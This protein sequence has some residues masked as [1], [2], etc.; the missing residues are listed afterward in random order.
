MIVVLLLF[1]FLNYA[2]RFLR[3]HLYLKAMQVPIEYAKSFKVFMAGL[4]MTV[5]PGKAGEVFK[6]N[7]LHDETSS[8][9]ITGVSVVFVERLMD[10]VGVVLL[11]LL[12]TLFF[13]VGKGIAVVGLLICFTI[14]LVFTSPRLF[15]PLINL[16]AR[17]KRLSTAKD[18]TLDIYNNIRNLLSWRLFILTTFLSVIAWFSECLVLYFALIACGC[19]LSI[20]HATFV[21]SLSTLAGALSMIPGGLIATEG[22][23]TGLLFLFGIAFDQGTLV[24][25]I[26]RICTL[27]FAV[28]LGALF[29]MLLVRDGRQRKGEARDTIGKQCSG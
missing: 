15:V 23:M 12:G 2:L 27:W 6:S 5:T 10:L 25:L 3:W 8:P 14:L 13:P 19:K 7:F 18:K 26:V 11:V 21:Y 16:T 4:S 29:L 24:T 1:A 9:W 17:I 22:S 28:L 20:V